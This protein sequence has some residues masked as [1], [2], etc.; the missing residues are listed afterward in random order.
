MKPKDSV[1]INDPSSDAH[2]LTGVIVSTYTS[3]D[4]AVASV[5]FVGIISARWF[6][7]D[8]LQPAPKFVSATP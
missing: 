1:Q 7:Q 5:R 8:Q 4:N 3:T 6:R 2:G